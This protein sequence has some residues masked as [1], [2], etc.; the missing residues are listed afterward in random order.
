MHF[1]T[2]FSILV[3]ASC[4]S[5]SAQVKSVRAT[6][7]VNGNVE[8]EQYRSHVTLESVS[9]NGSVIHA[10]G[11]VKLNLTGIRMNKTVGRGYAL[12]VS[13]ASKVT[14]FQCDVNLHTENSYG[15]AATGSGTL[16]K[17][18]D[19]RTTVSKE[20][21]AGFYCTDSAMISID[22]YDI[23]SYAKMSPVLS[24][25]NMGS[26]EAVGMKGGTRGYA[27]P[28]FSSKGD[29][30]VSES[31]MEAAS[32]PIAHVRCSG[33][34]TLDNCELTQGASCGIYVSE[35]SDAGCRL[36]MNSCRLKLHDGPLLLV[37]EGAVT[38]TLTDNTISFTKEGLLSVRGGTAD[39]AAFRQKLTGDIVT[40]SICKVSLSL[41]KG[42]SYNGAINVENN[43]E[44]TVSVNLEKGS[45]WFVSD[46]SHIS[47]ISFQQGVENGVK[48]I[49]GKANVYYDAKNPANSYLGGR[50]Y[51][52]GGQ[53]MLIPE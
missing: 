4:M 19:G 46:N 38:A 35:G 41:G 39:I 10:Y 30:H 15:I 1:K 51:E 6:Y 18:D 28:L 43:V 25:D 34:V 13:E 26:I 37:D 31:R 50:Q 21:S 48:Q 29:I 42:A 40:D 16:I 27:A 2:V 8:K 33:A 53:G 36:V 24:T 20:R 9:D 22:K 12:L 3:A 47:A 44:A 52:L 49:K 45:V 23:S 5:A 17:V 7:D 14:V 11:A 32:A